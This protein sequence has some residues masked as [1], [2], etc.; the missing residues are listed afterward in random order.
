[1]APDRIY[2][3]RFGTWSTDPDGENMTE[4][5]R[6]DLFK[7]GRKFAWLPTWTANGWAWLQRVTYREAY[8]V[9]AY[10]REQK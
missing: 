1:M 7:V 3:H 5:V 4:Y 8:G 6:A 10:W 9:R 2:T